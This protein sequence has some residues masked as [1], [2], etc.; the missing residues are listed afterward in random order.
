[1]YILTVDQMREAEAAANAAGQTYEL[2]MESARAR[3]AGEQRG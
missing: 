3:R 1:M 2:M